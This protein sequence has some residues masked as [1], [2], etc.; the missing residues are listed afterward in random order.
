MKYF[1]H[2]EN[3]K[4]MKFDNKINSKSMKINQNPDQF[5]YYPLIEI[6]RKSEKI[7][8]KFRENQ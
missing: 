3:Q 7:D 6:D 4:S 5:L 1:S 8:N 2:F